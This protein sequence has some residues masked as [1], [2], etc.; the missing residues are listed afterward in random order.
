MNVKSANT[1]A[2]DILNDSRFV[3]MFVGAALCNS[4][5][6]EEEQIGAR[7]VLEWLD[8]RMS[9]TVLSLTNQSNAPS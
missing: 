3:M 2:L 6:S 1:N 7:I 4:N 8:S 9:T 5:Y